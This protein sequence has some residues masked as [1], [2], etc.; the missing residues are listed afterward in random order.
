MH[1]FREVVSFLNHP[2]GAITVITLGF[3]IFT[4]AMILRFTVFKKLPKGYQHPVMSVLRILTMAFGCMLLGIGMASVIPTSYSIGIL[5]GLALMGFS[6]GLA[7]LH[8]GGF[9]M[10]L[11]LRRNRRS[12]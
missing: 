1:I 4:T 5:F 8:Y 6:L 11:P 9:E 10:F 12:F 7:A 2:T 3:L